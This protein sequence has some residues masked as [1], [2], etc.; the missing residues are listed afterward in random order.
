[1]TDLPAPGDIAD[2]LTECPPA[3]GSGRWNVVSLQLAPY[4]AV[5]RNDLGRAALV[6][7]PLQG[8]GAW[9]GATADIAPLG[10]FTFESV[11]GEQTRDCALLAFDEAAYGGTLG[12]IVPTLGWGLLSALSDGG[13]EQAGRY[14]DSIGVLLRDSNDPADRL[15]TQGLWAELLVIINAQ[16]PELMAQAWH[17]DPNDTYDFAYGSERVE[18]KSSSGSLRR[19]KFSSAQLPPPDG[20]NLR[21]VSVLLQRVAGG[22]TVL[23]LLQL[24]KERV[25]SAASAQLLGQ[26]LLVAGPA[27]LARDG[28]DLLGAGASIRSYEASTVPTV[29][30]P[31]N[32]VQASWTADLTHLPPAPPPV[33]RLHIAASQGVPSG[34]E[35]L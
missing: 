14:A 18:V 17:Q 21:V 10:I 16:D 8:A 33:G 7:P 29:H 35:K 1:M 26:A 9:R 3:L 23:D 34:L 19:H 20:C 24:A 31:P 12:R 25:S 13:V 32:V 4:F 22:Q 2:A 28:Y 15:A 27:Q 6:Y 30:L 11:T 5:A